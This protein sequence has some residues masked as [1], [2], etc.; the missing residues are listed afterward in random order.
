MTEEGDSLSHLEFPAP[1][2]PVGTPVLSSPSFQPDLAA[3]PLP[4]PRLS[5]VIPALQLSPACHRA[6][7]QAALTAGKNPLLLSSCFIILK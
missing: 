6:F 2:G 5:Q 4:G 1:W 3:G 7:A